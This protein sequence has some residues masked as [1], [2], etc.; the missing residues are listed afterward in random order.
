MYF[1]MGRLHMSPLEFVVSC[2]A[3]GVFVLI[4]KIKEEEK[5]RRKQ[6][7]KTKENKP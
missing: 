1:L 4:E 7:E 6:K 5:E 3:V 2:A